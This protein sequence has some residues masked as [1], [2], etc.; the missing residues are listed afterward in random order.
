M[1]F[2][3][4]TLY[5]KELKEIERFYCTVLG[6]NA[7]SN[8][9]KKLTLSVGTSQ[10]IFEE[11][12]EATPYHFAFNIP[13]NQENEA[14]EWLSE[15]AE[16]IKADGI[17]IHDFDFWNAKAMYFLDPDNNIVELIA[18][19]NLQNNSINP[20][21]SESILSVCE[22]GLPC[23]SVSQIF[24]QLNTCC[25]LEKFSGDFDVFCAI[26]GEEGLIIAI[27]KNNRNWFPIDAKAFA[28]EFILD[29]EFKDTSS[30][31]EYKGGVLALN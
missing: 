15:K 17:E 9:G 26:G 5:T 13:C 1:R 29:F 3:S 18:R 24:S 12:V 21:S 11:K 6:L 28:S 30:R 25:S 19:K 7:I 22:I 2:K 16:V 14:F 8:D 10:L 31:I 4:L 23:E 27:D 20:F